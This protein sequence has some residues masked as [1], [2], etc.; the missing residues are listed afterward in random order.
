MYL[1][2]FSRIDI[3]I[4]LRFTFEVMATSSLNSSF[5]SDLIGWVISKKLYL[6]GSLIPEMVLYFPFEYSSI[7]IAPN[8]FVAYFSSTLIW[9]QQS[10]CKAESAQLVKKVVKKIQVC[11][12]LKWK[13]RLTPIPSK[14]DEQRWWLLSLRLQPGKKLD[15]AAEEKKVWMH[16]WTKLEIPRV[17]LQDL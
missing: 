3:A 4:L 14:S 5:S 15:R 6:C 16:Q 9:T 13:N 2:L 12:W 1:T 7:L 10:S 17:I 8:S 11:V